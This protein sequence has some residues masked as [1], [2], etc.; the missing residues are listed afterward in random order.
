[1]GII[2]HH[3]K[4]IKKIKIKKNYFKIKIKK[5]LIGLDQLEPINKPLRNKK[6]LPLLIISVNYFGLIHK[7]IVRVNSCGHNDI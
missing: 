2:G 3:C 6:T 7:S 4:I 1:M 5:K